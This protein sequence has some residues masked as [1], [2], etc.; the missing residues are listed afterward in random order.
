MSLEEKMEAD[1]RSI[2]FVNARSHAGCR[3][4]WGLESLLGSHLGSGVFFGV[5]G[6]IWGLDWGLG[7]LMGS[8]LGSG[9]SFGV[10]GLLWGLFW[11]RVSYGVSFWVWGLFWG[12]G[13]L[14]GPH[15]GPGVSFEG[16]FWGLGSPLG[17]VGFSMGHWAVLWGTGV[18]YGAR[19]VPAMGW[20]PSMGHRD[21]VCSW[22]LPWGTGLFYG[23][24][25]FPMGQEGPPLWGRVLCYGVTS[26]P[27]PDPQPQVDYGATAEEL[28]A[29]FHG[30]GSVNRV[31]ILCDKYSGHPKGSVPKIPLNHP[32]INPK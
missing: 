26:P 27:C 21:L 31:T 9:F 15:L 13:S 19:G 2:C 8:D 5:W 17:S 24:L 22:G 32:K 12:L 18:S 30:C 1:A 25:G 28:E 23:A 14:L 16:P 20:R 29:H 10:W 6:L 3:P 7:S 4:F 11:G